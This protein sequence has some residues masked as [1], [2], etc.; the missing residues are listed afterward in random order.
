MF[1]HI[2]KRRKKG[3]RTAKIV[4]P[5]EEDPEPPLPTITTASELETN[6][7]SYGVLRMAEPDEELRT[8]GLGDKLV[9]VVDVNGIT[10]GGGVANEEVGVV[11]EEGGVVKEEGGVVKEGEG[12]EKVG[13][14]GVVAQA[15]RGKARK[16]SRRK[17]KKGKE[18]QEGKHVQ[19]LVIFNL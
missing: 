7:L 10:E 2:Q 5:D 3:Q 4:D 17:K 15:G 6:G 8:S 14:V 13:G 9:V 19:L 1:P 18:K 16:V 12:E 11:K